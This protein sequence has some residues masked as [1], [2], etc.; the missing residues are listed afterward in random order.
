MSKK[1][2][3]VIA[4]L[5]IIILVLGFFIIRNHNSKYNY[6]ITTISLDE[7]RYFILKQDETYGVIDKEGKTIIEPKFSRVVIPNPT[8]AIF[9]V[10]DPADPDGVYRA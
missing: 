6:Q 9:I 7:I 3:I 4:I 1:G 2:K 8:K 5:L 10:S